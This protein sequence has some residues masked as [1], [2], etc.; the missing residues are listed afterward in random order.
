MVV[1]ARPDHQNLMPIRPQRCHELLDMHAL[2][3]P[4]LNA[5]AV[6]NPHARDFLQIA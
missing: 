3:I 1:K 2:P 5:V 6:E 4:R